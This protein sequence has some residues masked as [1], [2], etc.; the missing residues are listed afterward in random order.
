MYSLH[1]QEGYCIA[2]MLLS[3]YTDESNDKSARNNTID[4]NVIIMQI[5]CSKL[6]D[7]NFSNTSH[8]VFYSECFGSIFR[9]FAR[10]DM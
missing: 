9:A 5:M 7:E 3:H 2:V 8:T 1:W 4:H 10:N 6:F